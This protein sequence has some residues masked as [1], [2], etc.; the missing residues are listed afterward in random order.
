MALPLMLQI[1]NVKR[2]LVYNA[3]S[4]Y[5]GELQGGLTL[6]VKTP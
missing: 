6:C 4:E 1:K 2:N 3:P 5:T